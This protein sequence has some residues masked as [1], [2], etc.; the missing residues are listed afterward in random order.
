MMKLASL[1]AA[2]ALAALPLAAH[3][4]DNHRDDGYARPA[5]GGG[6][7]ASARGYDRTD[8]RAGYRGD[9]PYGGDYDAY[10][11]GGYGAD[12]AYSYPDEYGTYQPFAYGYSARDDAYYAG[13]PQYDDGYGDGYDRGFDGAG[14]VGW[15]VGGPP[16]DCG[17]W[18]WRED[19]AA[20]QW[21]P[22]PCQR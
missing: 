12:Y 10:P 6:Y 3:T 21:A 7:D 11:A 14:D 20:Y 9:D 15:S 22:A 5:A 4:Q 13:D 8:R 18:I 2:A 17:R 1:V 19:R 16:V